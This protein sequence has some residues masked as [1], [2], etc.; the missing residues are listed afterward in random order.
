[1]KVAITG[2]NGY[3]GQALCQYLT[4]PGNTLL[5]ITRTPYTHSGCRNVVGT[6]LAHY[7]LRPAIQDF[8]CLIHLASRV[9][10][11]SDNKKPMMLYRKDNVELS[12]ALAK[13]AIEARV[14]R[15]IYISSI[16][17]NGEETTH[18]FTSSDTPKPTDP[19]GISKHEAEMGLTQLLKNSDTEL[20]IIRPPLVWG[21]APKGNMKTLVNFI[22]RGI[23]LPFKGIEN[24]RD[25]VS[26][27][28]LCSLIEKSAAH[29]NAAGEIFLVSDGTPRTTAEIIKLVEKETSRTAKLITIPKIFLAILKLLPGVNSRMRKLTGN[30]EID[31]SDTQ[32]KLDWRPHTHL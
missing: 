19:Y 8:D 24:R 14:K 23:P 27:H 3:V 25:L 31:I 30:L 11:T 29:P 7:D 18:P 2:A 13:M 32:K 5:A 1:M 9:H 12:L 6:D 20:V 22:E 10:H 26:L 4:K 15:F 21:G 28:N 17:V 16:K